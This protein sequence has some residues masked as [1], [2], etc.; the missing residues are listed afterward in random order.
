MD[1]YKLAQKRSMTPEKLIKILNKHG[2][3]VSIER[4]E[5]ILELIYKLSNL[6]IKETLSELPE[7]H[8]KENRKI[9]KR[10]TRKSKL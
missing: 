9:F 1:Y 4:A 2:T 6:S 7:R 10:H 3:T 8:A 5:K